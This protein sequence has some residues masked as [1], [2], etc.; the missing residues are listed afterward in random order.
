MNNI[1]EGIN[2]DDLV[3][4]SLEILDYSDRI[5]ELFDRIDDCMEKL[6]VHY[7]GLSSSKLVNYYK[8]LK[9]CYYVIKQNIISYS[10]D[11]IELIKKMK[12]NDRCLVTLFQN[13]TEDAINKIRSI[14]K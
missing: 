8:D 4:L 13:Y 12:E 11:L 7:N 2:E 14:N 5:S 1:V 6:P 9:P 3:S 10:D